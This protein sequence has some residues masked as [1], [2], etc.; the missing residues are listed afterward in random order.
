MGKL[1]FKNYQLIIGELKPSK[2][3]IQAI[4]NH[5]VKKHQK[6]DSIYFFNIDF[7]E[8]SNIL[9]LYASYNDNKAYSEKVYNEHSALMETNPKKKEQRELNA[10]FF[11][12]YSMDKDILYLTNSRKKSVLEEYFSGILATTVEI[13]NILHSIDKFIQAIIS[14]K[15]ISFIAKDNLYK[16][17]KGVFDYTNSAYGLD[18]PESFYIKACYGNM[19]IKGLALD[20]LKRFVKSDKEEEIQNLVISGYDDEGFE[21]I[22]RPDAYIET[23]EIFCEQNENGLYEEKEVKNK[24]LT[25]TRSQG[26][27]F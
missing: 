24:L 15:D 25:M 14:L 19:S 4:I 26:I 6:Q 22:F 23:L 5:K 1:S 10:Q 16:K 2:Q 20:F 27:T 9:W 8:V 3:N 13:K 7:C 17:E 12:A 11:A 18:Y 21:K